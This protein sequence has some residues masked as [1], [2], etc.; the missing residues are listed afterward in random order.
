M[1]ASHDRIAC[2]V[3]CRVSWMRRRQFSTIMASYHGFGSL[4]PKPFGWP[5]QV[6]TALVFGGILLNVSFKQRSQVQELWH[7]RF[8]SGRSNQGKKEHKGD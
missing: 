2:V 7:R 4:H 1:D 6:G 5:Q 3:L 8:G